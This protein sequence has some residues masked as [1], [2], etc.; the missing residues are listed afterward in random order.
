MNP[1][2]VPQLLDAKALRTAYSHFPTGVVAVCAQV[3]GAPVGMAVSAFVPVSLQPP[4]IA[5]C[6]QSSSAT[7]P[8]LREGDGLGVSVL[9]RTQQAVAQQLSGKDRDRFVGNDY[10]V[11]PSGAILMNGAQLGLDCS[12]HDISQ[13][14]DHDLVLLK[15][16]QVRD[17]RGA[18]DPMVFHASS[19]AGLRHRRGPAIFEPG[20]LLLW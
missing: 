13:A 4:L 12:L 3:D 14:G 2:M 1:T 15:V 5:I 17:G 20:E 18:E 6:I 10:V 7:W 9:S 19:F 16:D 8:Q 11:T